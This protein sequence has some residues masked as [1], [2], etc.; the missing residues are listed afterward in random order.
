[1][2]VSIKISTNALDLR[3]KLIALATKQYP[4]A[5]AKTLTNLAKD[6]QA[7]E[8]QHIPQ[9]FEVRT[10]WSLNT[11][12][13]IPARKQDFPAPYAILGVRDKVM[14]LNIT[15][16]TDSSSNLSIPGSKSV[17]AKLNPSNKTLGPAYFPSRLLGKGGKPKK[18]KNYGGNRA[19]MMNIKKT[20]Q[21]A[22]AVR[23]SD[24][25]LPLEILYLFTKS[26]K[27]P[28]RWNLYERSK[29]YV[30]RNYRS[31]LAKNVNEAIN[32]SR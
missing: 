27:T 8:K 3:S 7:Q 16:G 4:F 1:M 30:N 32:N 21:R 11:I 9:I 24:D 20:G 31:L 25:R 26:K 6:I 12:K 13:V 23:T 28:R 18:L 19:F 14:A 10:K 29:R 15:G 17:R 22:V 2:S 5:L